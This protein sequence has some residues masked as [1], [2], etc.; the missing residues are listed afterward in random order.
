MKPLYFPSKSCFSN[1]QPRLSEQQFHYSSQIGPKTSSSYETFVFSCLFQE[2]LFT[3][4]LTKSTEY[5]CNRYCLF[6][7]L[8]EPGNN[9]VQNLG[10]CW[11]QHNQKDS[12]LVISRKHL[13]I[14]I[15]QAFFPLA[16]AQK[17]FVDFESI[18]IQFQ[19]FS[20][21]GVL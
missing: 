20:W 5:M 9:R 2:I 11:L 8:N 6:G 4:H 1:N 18:F 17:T 15:F 14:T 12:S 7:V 13:H 19:K 10:T 21:I 3:Q 16:R